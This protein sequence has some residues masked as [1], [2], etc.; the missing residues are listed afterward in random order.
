V[1]IWWWC[2]SRWFEGGAGIG[3]DGPAAWDSSQAGG[4]TE[5]AEDVGDHGLATAGGW[6]ERPSSLS[7][8]RCESAF[9]MVCCSEMRGLR[10]TVGGVQEE[11]QLSHAKA[12]GL[13]SYKTVGMRRQE[14]T[15]S[16]EA[17][18]TGP[19]GGDDLR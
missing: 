10:R 3:E 9:K 2:G 17:H 11:K 15:W 8:V 16:D 5:D 4:E 13:R 12:A 14:Q 1:V 6:Q 19:P 18:K 7:V